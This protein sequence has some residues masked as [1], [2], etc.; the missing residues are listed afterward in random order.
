MKKKIFQKKKT[1]TKVYYTFKK[2]FENTNVN[3]V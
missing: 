1:S 3:K 2:A